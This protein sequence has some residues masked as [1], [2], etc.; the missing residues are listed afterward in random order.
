MYL[1]GNDFLDESAVE[2]RREGQLDQ[3]A[4]RVV[5]VELENDC[6]QLALGRRLRQ[7]VQVALDANLRGHVLL[8]ARVDARIG[9]V[10]HLDDVEDWLVRQN[11]NALLQL[12]LDRL[13]D[14]FAVDHFGRL[15]QARGILTQGDVM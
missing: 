1:L 6:L 14:L 11:S 10:A 13:R 9:P 5:G 3:E 2:V 4:S 12:L 8:H 15:V 7:L